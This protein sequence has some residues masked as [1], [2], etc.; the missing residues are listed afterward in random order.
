VNVQ[1]Y[2]QSGIIESYVLGMANEQEA[3]ELLQLSQQYPEIKQAIDSFEASLENAAFT[4]AINPPDSLKNKLFETLK[5]D[6]AEPTHA[7]QVT[8]L[9]TISETPVRAIGSR[10]K[11][12]AAASVILLIASSALNFYLY[13]E[14]KNVNNNYLSLLKENNS[15]TADN[16]VY[17]TKMLD[18]Y[19]NMQLM[20]DPT[21]IK[22]AMPGVAGKEN[23]LTTVFW[24]SKTKDVYLLA[25]KLP[26]AEEGK[27]YQLWALVDGKPVDA[28][29]LEDCNGLCKL[30]NIQKA[31][32]FAITLEVKGGS[33]TPHLEQLYV[34][35]KVG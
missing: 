21:M 35:G 12:L 7:K 29:L 11:Y 31:Q 28:G 3:T 34:L 10:F 25:N 8:S 32:A 33:P 9:N 17:Q 26:K 5:D 30:K 20:S 1:D 24:D 15:V 27:Q 19:N 4:N 23:N 16:R 2:I 6:F 14:Y 22:V 18:L 13:K